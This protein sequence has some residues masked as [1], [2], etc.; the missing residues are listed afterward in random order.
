M[1][2]PTLE[3]ALTLGGCTAITVAI[4]AIL[5]PALSL[6]TEASNRFGPLLAVGI[7]EVVAFGA[8]FLVITGVG[9]A[10]IG[11]AIIVGLFA[12][13][14]AIGTHQVVK[15]TVLSQPSS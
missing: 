1:E 15:K 10:D 14:S 4:M 9:R 8:T 13:L 5:L 3:V 12:G 11:S 6:T 2:A 7:A